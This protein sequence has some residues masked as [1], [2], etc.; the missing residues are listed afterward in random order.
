MQE[1]GMVQNNSID[2]NGHKPQFQNINQGTVAVESSRA[3]AEVQ[4]KLVIA[5][6]FPRNYTAS[7]TK[8]IEACQRKPFA[9]KAFYS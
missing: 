2:T 8:A 7:Y 9:E 3:I 5:K 6:N 1:D 4:G